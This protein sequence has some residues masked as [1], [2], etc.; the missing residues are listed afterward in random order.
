MMS[1][2][3]RPRWWP[4]DGV[5]VARR[6]HE[7]GVLHCPIGYSVKHGRD[8]DLRLKILLSPFIHQNVMNDAYLF[9]PLV[10]VR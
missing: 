5:A 6:W 2:V 8:L 10:L 4:D 7:P 3:R 1:S 9:I